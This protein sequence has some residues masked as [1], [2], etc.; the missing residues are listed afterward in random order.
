MEHT[1]KPECTMR[2]DR[3]LRFAFPGLMQSTIEQGIRKKLIK[4]NDQICLAKSKI[5]GGE[6]LSVPNSFANYTNLG[7]KIFSN[8]VQK[9]SEKLFDKFVLHEDEQILVINKPAKLPT[10]GGNKVN[11]CVDD[12]LKYHNSVYGTNMRI[13]HRLDKD[14]TGVLLIAKNRGISSQVA[15]AFKHHLIRKQYLA[16]I[17]GKPKALKGCIT[18][19]IDETEAVSHYKVVQKFSDNLWCILFTPKTGKMHQIRK[20]ALLVGGAIV[21]DQKYNTD[22]SSPYSQNL[23]LHAAQVALPNTIT[24]LH[25]KRFYA[26]TPKHWHQFLSQYSQNRFIRSQCHNPIAKENAQ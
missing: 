1:A 18:S 16:L 7:P 10:Q 21:G 3:Y 20:H 25:K 9:F 2:L 19:E 23:M 8:C 22:I 17:Y 14:T 15:H 4:I 11:L 5:T 24:N 12:A 26:F 6:I 13:V